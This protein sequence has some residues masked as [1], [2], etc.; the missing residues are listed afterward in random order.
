MI[1]LALR[2]RFSFLKARGRCLK[3]GGYRP[4]GRAESASKSMH[5]QF[6]AAT[7]AA[8]ENYQ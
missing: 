5:H 4:K 8:E 7:N 6:T 3:S 1:V 2:R